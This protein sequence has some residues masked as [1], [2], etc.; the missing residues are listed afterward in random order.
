[1]PPSPLA[2]VGGRVSFYDEK[3][4]VLVTEGGRISA[5][6]LRRRVEIPADAEIV[7]AHGLTLLPG[8]LDVHV[9]GGGGADTMD[10]TPD[11]LR[12]VA[13]THAAHGTTG[14][15]ATTIT[16]SRDAITRALANAR[17]ARDAG[18]DF[19]PDG[20]QVLGVHLEGP[21]IAPGK[22]G[23]QPREFVRDYDAEE[24][25]DWLDAAGDGT[26]KLITLAPE[27]RGADE[28]IAACRGA[29]VVVSIGHTEADAQATE[30][31]IG[32]GATH[33]THLFNAM[34]P[35]HHRHPGPIPILLTNYNVRS[36]EIIADGHH[37]AP[38]TIHMALRTRGL[39]R[40]I[41]ITDAIRGAG[42]GDGVYDLGGHAA[43]V[44]DGVATLADGTLAGSVLTMDRAIANIIS[45]NNGKM[46]TPHLGL[47]WQEI[48]RLTSRNAADEMGW[49]SKG[50]LTV[51]A[52]ADLVLVDDALNVHATFVAG[53][54]V[55]TRRE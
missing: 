48:I 49:K 6:N 32:L 47:P 11:A 18:P 53:R 42:R 44:R 16:Q 10:A 26:I 4:G 7:D 8:F 39:E 1:M 29:G 30:R 54:R 25:A 27:R 9:H 37:V 12:T 22:A 50:R 19:C 31:A 23:A 2:F 17:A 38:E 43:T 55:Y 52:D 41:L 14:F 20:A 33:A 21:Y 35:I 13:R 5:V 34:P 15:L 36:V 24:F 3:D 28:L 40:T 45:W 51:G 46:G